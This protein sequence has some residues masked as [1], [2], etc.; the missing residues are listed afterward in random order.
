MNIDFNI[1]NN[2]N[3]VNCCKHN[4]LNSR[5]LVNSHSNSELISKE[6]SNCSR[7]VALGGLSFA[8]KFRL[9][10]IQNVFQG[11]FMDKNIG[12]GEAKVMLDRYK[13]LE[14]ISDKSEYINAVFEEAKRN[15]GFKE[16]GIQ[17]EIM[18]KNFMKKAF[19]AA[20]D[21]FCSIRINEDIPRSHVLNIIHHEFRHMKQK[22]I[23]Y[24]FSPEKYMLALNQK[25]ELISDGK[26]KNAWKDLNNFQVWINS[27]L[28]GSKCDL[29]DANFANKVLNSMKN[30]KDFETDYEGYF[31][32]FVEKDARKV[33]RDIEF[34]VNNY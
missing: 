18:P 21:A 14:E 8:D 26:K 17:L 16:S 24:N 12:I 32:N 33:G 1:N 13:D 15:F 6:A 2:I 31:E 4:A 10:H 20:D 28:G 30:H 34:L 5:L 7:N 11:V 23:A 19:G 3:E 25:I 27:N 22:Q 9:K 29:I